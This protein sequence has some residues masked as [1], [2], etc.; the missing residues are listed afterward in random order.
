MTQT[1]FRGRTSTSAKLATP[2]IIFVSTQLNKSF[3][4]KFTVYIFVPHSNVTHRLSIVKK[5]KTIEMIIDS[6]FAK[7]SNTEWKH[8]YELFGR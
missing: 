5:G 2:M 4:E 8:K 1:T 7:M 3:G 6:Q